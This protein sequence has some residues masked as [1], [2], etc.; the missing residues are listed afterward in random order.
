LWI[1][2]S[3]RMGLRMKQAIAVLLT[4]SLLL[5]CL[6]SGAGDPAPEKPAPLKPL[7]KGDLEVR[8]H[9]LGSLALYSSWL[10][11]RRVGDDS[12]AN[13]RVEA[14]W[15]P[16]P[17]PQE[18]TRTK[19]WSEI[20]KHF[21]ADGFFDLPGNRGGE[22]CAGEGIPVDENWI[23][24]EVQR[25]GSY[26]EFSYYAPLALKCARA[27]KFVSTLTF[28]QEAFNR[29]LPVPYKMTRCTRDG[30]CPSSDAPAD[31]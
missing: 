20:W 19:P 6:G 14:A 12:G 11:L 4:V 23:S 25:G 22:A 30:K 10:T 16:I 3:P 15:M 13:Y 8:I 18:L 26:R 17:Q 28:L 31:R 24:V 7:A 2:H 1:S 29:E 5:P 27:D 9:Y 21:E